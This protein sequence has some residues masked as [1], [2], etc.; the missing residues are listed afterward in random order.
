M[1]PEK[2]ET[3]TKVE[4]RLLVWLFS[5]LVKGLMQGL[6]ELVQQVDSEGKI[7]SKDARGL[8]TKKT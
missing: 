8:V 1:G 4:L 2:P 6:P 7:W 5:Y 3:M